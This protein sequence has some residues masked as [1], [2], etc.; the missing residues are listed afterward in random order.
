MSGPTPSMDHLPFTSLSPVQTP[1]E[2]DWNVYWPLETAN[3]TQRPDLIPAGQGWEAG[4]PQHSAF[5]D[6]TF[7]PLAWG[8]E[9]RTTS[10]QQ[11]SPLLRTRDTMSSFSLAFLA[12][13]TSTTGFVN[14]FDCGTLEERRRVA[15]NAMTIDSSEFCTGNSGSE[16]ACLPS[17]SSTENTVEDSVAELEAITHVWG[18]MLPDETPTSGMPTQ[19]QQKA[20]VKPLYTK[21]WMQG[22]HAG[23]RSTST[24]SI[25]NP[26]ADSNLN[27]DVQGGCPLL[28]SPLIL[29]THEIM[30]RIKEVVS[31]KPRNSIVTLT[32][33]FLLEQV[34]L[35]FFSPPNLLKYL[36]LYWA[37]WHPNWPVIH[38]PT[39][40]PISAHP[41]LVAAMAL[42]GIILR[43]KSSLDH[44]NFRRSLCVA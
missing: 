31:L 19:H 32:W 2:T 30:S 17:V 4:A 9:D 16:E 21:D 39:F 34:C 24:A 10:S 27:F 43:F 1:I 35:Q 6:F 15:R 11:E 7:S 44:T 3:Y 13:F 20:Q 25:T 14:S 42:V 33:S 18:F 29:V 22:P 28:S 5:M 38:K 36:E 23:L 8:F 26:S 40:N 41:V 37:C 12:N